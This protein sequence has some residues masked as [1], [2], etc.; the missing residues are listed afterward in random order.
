[1]RIVREY[2]RL[3]RTTV[4]YD[5]EIS[6]A[7]GNVDGILLRIRRRLSTVFGFRLGRSRRGEPQDRT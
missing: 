2:F 6:G 5:N 4:V 7:G 1:M 3:E